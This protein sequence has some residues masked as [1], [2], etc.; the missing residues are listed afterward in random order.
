MERATGFTLV[1]LM[2]VVAIIGILAAVAVPAYSDYVTRGKLV[3]ATTQLADGRVKMEQYYQDNRKYTDGPLPT[4][5]KYFTYS[6]TNPP[7]DT[8]YDIAAEGIGNLAGFTYSIDQNNTKS[9]NTPWG[10]GTTC[11]IMRKGDSC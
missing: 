2:V 5:T 9:S 6:F 11:W 10:N 1:E 4:A 3:E 7:T 8:T